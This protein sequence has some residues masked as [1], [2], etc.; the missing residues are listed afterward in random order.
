MATLGGAAIATLGGV[1]GNT[2]G[3][4]GSGGGELGWPDIIRVSC[5][6]ALRCFSLAVVVVG[7][8]R[9]SCCNRSAAASKVMLCSDVI[10]TWQWLGYKCHVSEKQ[11]CWVAGV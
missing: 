5:P 3:D 6:M 11:K 9:P 4:V 7:I 10:G 2:H 1:A 8:A